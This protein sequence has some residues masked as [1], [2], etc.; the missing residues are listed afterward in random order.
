[1][2]KGKSSHHLIP[3]PGPGINIR[4]NFMKYSASGS[5]VRNQAKSHKPPPR[6]PV[7]IPMK[8]S[9]HRNTNPS[10]HLNPKP[11]MKRKSSIPIRPKKGNKNFSLT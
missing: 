8:R 10:P 11:T 1:M 2:K 5:G 7:G 4:K 9:H 3:K 6:P